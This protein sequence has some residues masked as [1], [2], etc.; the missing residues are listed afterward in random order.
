M[1]LLA[2]MYV[3]Q[4]DIAAQ[5]LT[6]LRQV[7]FQT[8]LVMAGEL[9]SWAAVRLRSLGR[10]LWVAADG[11]YAKKAFLKAAA[12]AQVIVVSRLSGN[13]WSGSWPELRQCR[14]VQ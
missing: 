1:P 12:R 3:H 7:T 11:A 8:K 5:Q 13:V 10:K 14:K 4:K 2:R 6:S 9:V